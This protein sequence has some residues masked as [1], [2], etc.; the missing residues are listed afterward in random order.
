MKTKNSQLNLPLICAL[1]FS[2][3]FRSAVAGETNQGA[4]VAAPDDFGYDFPALDSLNR[5]RPIIRRIRESNR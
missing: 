2:F 3:G 5:I 1:C 4:N